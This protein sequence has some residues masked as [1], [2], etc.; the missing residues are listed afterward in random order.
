MDARRD[1]ALYYAFGL[2]A[3]ALV[4]VGVFFREELAGDGRLLLRYAHAA[5]LG[6]S[7][8]ACLVFAIR[9]RCRLRRW[10]WF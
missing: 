6:L 1:R 5:L 7:V 2:A 10:W 4:L 8:G 3:L 9:I